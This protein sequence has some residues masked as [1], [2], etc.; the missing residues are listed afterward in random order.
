MSVDVSNMR[1]MLSTKEGQAYKDSNYLDFFL[2][3]CDSL[4]TFFV[5]RS[6]NHPTLFKCNL[7]SYLKDS[8]SVVFIFTLYSHPRIHYM[9]MGHI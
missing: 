1:S 6:G 7:A 8:S 3:F 9:R 2:F 5:Y 4:K